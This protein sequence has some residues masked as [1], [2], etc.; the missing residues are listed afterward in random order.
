MD[1][2][3]V[4]L[5]EILC[6][7]FFVSGIVTFM[8]T[9]FGIRL[10]ILQGTS[11]SVL[12]SVISI[13]SHPQWKC[14]YTEA[15]NKYGENVTFT[16]AGLPA[17]GSPEHQE[18]W[19]KRIRE[20]QGALIVASL[21][22]MVIGFTGVM[23]FVLRYIGPLVI[24]PTVTLVGLS[25]FRTGVEMASQQW[26]I[27]LMTILLITI[28]SQYFTNAKMPCFSC[29]N[30]NSETR[31]KLPLFTLFPVM[32][33]TLISWGVCAVLTAA[34]ALSENPGEWGYAA[35][36]DIRL[37]VLRNAKFFRFPYPGQWGL[38]TVTVASV[39]GVLAGVL[40]AMFK[41][42]GDYYA[43]AN[44]S[45]APPPPAYAI[46]RAILV[47]GL[48]N[49]LAGLWGTGQGTS[50]FSQ[51]IGVIGITKVGSRLVFQVA[52]CI[53][54]A[55]GCLGKFGAVFASIPEPIVGGLFMVTFGMITGVG[56]SNLQHVDLNSPR[57]IFIVGVSLFLGLSIP[58]WMK[59]NPNAINTG[60][61]VA[62]QILSVLLG[63]NMLVGALVA[64]V[65]DNT[66]QGT[67]EE[68]GIIALLRKDI[69]TT[70][71]QITKQN[72]YWLPFIQ[73]RLNNISTLRYFPICPSF[74]KA[75]EN[76][77]QT[78]N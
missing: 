44:V 32:L 3:Y 60:S 36:I 51:N 40:A 72:V 6:T 15:R 26:W 21:F 4:A 16:D 59:E 1:N 35:R 52:A 23:G 57:N 9:T 38:P 22:Q 20:I 49:L 53:M 33:A 41:S 24:T 29:G 47:E 11:I 8:Q 10:P 2:D 14:P 5:S 56:L 73:E 17:V 62:D 61:E 43:C 42:I 70:E 71:T 64:F 63:T 55:L 77:A 58:V 76:K 46:N 39:F 27:A 31:F 50:S 67:L 30:E 66:I 74:L 13:L 37:H 18:I 68:R 34:G 78:S 48:G 28:F 19:H 54:I 69:T 65:L 7:V 75:R 45:G 25:L 12:T